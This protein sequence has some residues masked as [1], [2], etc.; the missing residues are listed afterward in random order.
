[1]RRVVASAC[2][3]LAPACALLAQKRGARNRPPQINAFILSSKT[4]LIPCPPGG[5]S[6]ARPECLS[7]G[8]LKLKLWA[9]ASDPD[10]DRLVYRFQVG[11]GRIVGKG[12][13]VVWDLAGVAPGSYSV[14]LLVKDRRGGTV[15]AS[16]SV[17]V[18]ECSVCPLP[19]PSISVWC[20]VA[21]DEGDALAVSVNVSGGNPNVKPTYRWSVSAGRIVRGRRAAAVEVDTAG[22]AGRRLKVSVE[23]GGYPVEC[24][25]IESCEVPIRRR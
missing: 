22:L 25:K 9:F 12:Q 7:P 21:L 11:A 17:D 15:S 6:T 2:L 3:L 5:M 23:V 14:R 18:A 1:M 4:A 19:C 16:E 13:T 10:E 20:P 8:R 24:D